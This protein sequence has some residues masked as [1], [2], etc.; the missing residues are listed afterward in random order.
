MITKA[1]R[2]SQ[3]IIEKVAPYFNRHG[4]TGTSMSDICKIVGMTKG[5]I[6]GNFKDKEDLAIQAFNFNIRKSVGDL[7]PQI[8]AKDDA[9]DKLLVITSFYRKYYGRVIDDGGCPILNVGVD[10]I[11]H[12]NKLY[13]R[14]I[15][16]I[17]R[18]KKSIQNIIEKGQKEGS[19]KKNGKAIEYAD[20]IYA[21][22]Q[23]SIFMSFM[24]KDRIHITQMM[25]HIDEM[26]NT[27]MKV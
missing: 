3:L 12:N 14:V 19:I 4:Y 17:E 16:V 22:I 8:D 24:L 11:N 27:K 13:Q 2:T 7:S 5:A 18:L 9:V 15:V 26:I 10:S 6:Y 23:G 21:Q 20:K 25:D 1:E